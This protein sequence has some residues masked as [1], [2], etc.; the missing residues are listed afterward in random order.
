M[1]VMG[2]FLSDVL[3]WKG[4]DRPREPKLGPVATHPFAESAEGLGTRPF[5]RTK[6]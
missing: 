6:N 1:G 4:L 2:G 3:A 5:R